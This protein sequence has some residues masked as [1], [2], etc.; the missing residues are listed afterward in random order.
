[1]SNLN[2]DAVIAKHR[3][4]REKNRERLREWHRSNY[5]NRKASYQAAKRRYRAKKPWLHAEYQ[6]TRVAKLRMA[7]PAWVDRRAIRAVY[8]EAARLTTETGIQ[9]S[10]D[11]IVPLSSDRVCG[12]HVPWNL[13]VMPLADNARKQN[14]FDI[15]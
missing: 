6:R 15:E 10:V 3:R 1:M 13:R 12:L 2:P 8:K 9:Y 11:H 4:Y 14:R 5:A 7:M